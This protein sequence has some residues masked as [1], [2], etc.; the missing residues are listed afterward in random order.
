M[1]RNMLFRG[2]RTGDIDLEEW[3][4]PTRLRRMF[5]DAAR[6]LVR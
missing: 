1:D 4:E 6:L 5:E 3:A 2:V